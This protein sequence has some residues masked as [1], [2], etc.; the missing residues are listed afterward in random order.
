[1]FD[2]R[3]VVGGWCN[4]ENVPPHQQIN[5]N[6][7]RFQEWRQCEILFS[8]DLK[9]FRAEHPLVSPPDTT[10]AVKTRD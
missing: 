7:G 8:D 2:Q 5:H 1:L 9:K 10:G 3:F 6:P 4:L